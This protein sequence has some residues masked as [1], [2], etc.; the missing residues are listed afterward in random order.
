MKWILWTVVGLVGVVGLIAFVGW[1]LPVGHVASRSARFSQPPDA[2][3]AAITDVRTYADWWGEVKGVEM[4]EPVNGKVRFREN[5]STGPI[6]FEVDE[7]VPSTRYVT[8][9]A[10]DERAFGG[11]WTFELAP[12]SGGTRLTITERGEVYNPIFRFMS[13]FIF[14]Q[15]ATM[16]SFLRGLAKRFGESATV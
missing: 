14:S 1:L 16:E 12:E 13:H 2:V 15:T 6:V 10:G 3:Y 4:L 11:T 5:M 8:R 7:A 9:I